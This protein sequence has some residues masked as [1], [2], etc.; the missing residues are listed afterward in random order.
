MNHHKLAM[1]VLV[2]AAVHGA[3][4]DGTW[5]NIVVADGVTPGDVPGFPQA[6]FVP[7][8]FSNPLIGADGT[9]FFKAQCAGGPTSGPNGGPW[10]GTGG[11]ST[12]PQNSR[13]F[14]A[15]GASGMSIFARDAAPLPGG[16]LP[17]FQFNNATWASGV[18]TSNPFL[19]GNG[20][21]IWNCNVNTT[22]GTPTTSTTAPRI[23]TRSASGVDAVLYSPNMPYPDGSG[24][25]FTTSLGSPTYFNNNGQALL[26]AT[27]AGAGVVTSGPTQNNQAW[28][29]L[30]ASGA[31]AVIRRG[32]AAPGFTDGTTITPSGFG[33]Q[34]CGSNLLITGD[35]ANGPAGSITTSNNSVVMTNAGAAPG[36]LRIIG[37]KGSELSGLPGLFAVNQP[38]PTTNPFSAIT[39]PVTSNGAIFMQVRVSGTYP[40]GT[41]AVGNVNDTAILRELNGS[42]TIVLKAGDPVPGFEGTGLVFKSASTGGT[43]PNSNGYMLIAGSVMNPDGTSPTNSGFM[44]IRRPDGSITVLQKQGDPIPGIPG[45]TADNMISSASSCFNEQNIAVWNCNW[46]NGSNFGSAI[47]AWDQDQGMR[48]IAK[49]GDTNFTGTPVNQITLIGGTGINGDGGN[50]GLNSSGKLVLRAGDTANALYAISTIQLGPTAPSCPADLNDDGNVD[51]NDLGLLLAA[52]GPCPTSGTCAADLNDDGN[53][54]GNDL[55]LMLAAWGACP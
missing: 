11:S 25:T 51:G 43:T 29:L 31:T 47:M 24:A 40:D 54:D 32:D 33:G 5:Q 28:I 15:A 52:W 35:L 20:G 7:N 2:L 9:V 27:L 46:T 10:I 21:Y 48:V 38:F 6:V 36:S 44:A 19:N 50:S 1:S 22:T 23:L 55:G 18:T 16:L 8:A 4:A 45:A 30:S 42:W 37:R 14:I 34:M 12:A 26:Y 41:V 17:G 3:N 13:V 53:V 49:T 39:R